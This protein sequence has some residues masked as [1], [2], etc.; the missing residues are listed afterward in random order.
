M[1][2]ALERAKDARLRILGEMAQV[3]SEPRT[4]LSQYAPRIITFKIKQERIGDVIG[5]GG[6]MIRKIIEA[7]GAKIDIDDD[8][9]VLI[10]SVDGKAGQKAQEMIQGLVEEAEVDQ[11]YLG[12]V[13]R[14]A[15][16]GAFVEILPNTDGLLHIS[17]IAYER[18]NKV[19]D[20]M[21][22]GDQFEVKVL[23][24]DP[25]GKIRL[26]RKALLP[27]PEGWTDRPPRHDRDRDG[28]RHNDRRRSGRGG[29]GG[30]GRGRN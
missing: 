9:T 10:A 28:D 27:K 30:R 5:P 12:T 1:R 16:F 29:G 21:K 7:T 15:D 11:V 17:E 3:I 8:G 6:K 24:I 18:V 13:R 2:E 4:D 19:E 25:D 23:S 22:V 14:I 20:V 26:S